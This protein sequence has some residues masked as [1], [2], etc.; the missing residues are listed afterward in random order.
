[1]VAIPPGTFIM[2]TPTDELGRYQNEG[3][4]QV[5]ISKQ[6]L[7]SKYEIT[8][9]Q[10][11]KVIGTNPSNNQTNEFYPVENVCWNEAKAFCDKLNSDYSRL[12]PYGYKF[13]LPT[14]AQWEYAC[15]AGTTTALNNGKNLTSNGYCPNLNEVSWYR[16][17]SGNTTHQ[18]GQKKT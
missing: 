8:Q 6:F 4:H 13:D 15:R 12:I 3:Q 14:E 16:N 17:N 10:Y 7:I 18:V 11:V 1:M 5:T 9:K 2:G